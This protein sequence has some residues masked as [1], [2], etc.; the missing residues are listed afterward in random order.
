[1]V[2][3]EDVKVMMDKVAL[4]SGVTGQDGA[5][6]A[7][8]LRRTSWFNADRIDHLYQDPYVFERNFVFHHGGMTDS[9]NLVRIIQQAQP[10]ES[11]TL[12]GLER[13]Y[14]SIA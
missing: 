3:M 14:Q 7:E 11:T 10:D 9:S 13:A 1:M 8:S 5:Y 6:L 12:L 4:L 2:F